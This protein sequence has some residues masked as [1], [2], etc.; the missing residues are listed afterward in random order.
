MAVENL[1]LVKPT[2]L[3]KSAQEI[4]EVYVA[5]SSDKSV[6]LDTTL[7]RG[8]EQFLNGTHGLQAFFEAQKKV[9]NNL[10]ERFYR[11]FVLSGEYSMFVCQSEAEMDDLRAQNKDDDDLELNWNDEMDTTDED[12]IFFFTLKGLGHTIL[13]NFSIDQVVI[14]FTEMT[15]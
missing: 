5:P 6:K 15:K 1:K 8:M 7:I 9:F 4:Y 14:E 2:E 10:E 13:G 3:H 11:K 12:V